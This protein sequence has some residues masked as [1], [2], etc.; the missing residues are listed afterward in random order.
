MCWTRWVD[1]SHEPGFDRSE[2]S[3]PYP[4]DS[5]MCTEI[6]NI[7]LNIDDEET[8]QSHHQ[9][10][11]LFYAFGSNPP[12]GPFPFAHLF[13]TRWRAAVQVPLRTRLTFL[14]LRHLPSQRL[15]SPHMRRGSHRC[16][17][18]PTNA[19]APLQNDI[20]GA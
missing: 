4:I 15:A 13:F 7:V 19:L 18:Q 11:P 20:N 2:S 6:I 8:P 1:V 3:S 9:F 5:S 17:T 10:P 12:L 14:A 16:G